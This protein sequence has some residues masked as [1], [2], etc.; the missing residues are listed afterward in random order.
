MQKLKPVDLSA[1]ALISELSRRKIGLKIMCL[2]ALWQIFPEQCETSLRQL[3]NWQF[4]PSS[5]RSFTY[6]SA[7]A[8]R[9]GGIFSKE[10]DKKK[11]IKKENTLD[12]FYCT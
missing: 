11:Q 1:T 7:A 6:S 2:K 12:K 8:E 10:I 3:K 4:L 5:L 9:K